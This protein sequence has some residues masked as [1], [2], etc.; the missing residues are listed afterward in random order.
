[1]P[2]E[3]PPTSVAGVVADGP[4]RSSIES[5]IVWCSPLN[6]GRSGSGGIRYLTPIAPRSGNELDAAVLR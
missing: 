5:K 1:M 3:V 6:P 2:S 4:Y